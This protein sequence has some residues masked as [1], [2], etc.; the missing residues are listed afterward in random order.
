MQKYTQRKDGRYKT[1][2]WDGTYKD[3]EKHYIDV[4]STKSSRDLEMKVKEIEEKRQN[5]AIT[6]NTNVDVYDY[7]IAY[8]NRSKSVCEKSTKKNYMNAAYRLKSF[9]GLTF[10]NFTSQNIQEVFN[11][12]TPSTCVHVRLLIR[13]V[14]KAAEHDKLI[15]RGT[16]EE[17]FEHVYLPKYRAKEKKILDDTDKE[18]MLSADLPLQEKCFLYMLYYTGMRKSEALALT[19]DDIKDG[20]ISIT[21]AYGHG[22]DGYY[23]K[24]PKSERGTRRV[25]IPT[26][27]QEVLDQYLPVVDDPHGYLFAYDGNPWKNVK[28]DNI[29]KHIQKT[30]G[31]TITAHTLRHNYCTMLCYQS[32]MQRDITPK[33]I[34]ELL[35]DR[36]EMVMN[37][38][39]HI[40]EEK[41]N[42]VD[43]IEKALC[44]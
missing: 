1:R 17:I 3:G 21:K 40:V 26:R 24:P 43:A 33:K 41:E 27:L 7:I 37:V 2:V 11:S 39:S 20:Y 30:S 38:Y 5:G 42:T 14:G 12:I 16:T 29:W 4:Y 22:V 44:F 35:G 6:R 13:Q 28:F 31:V 8:I 15:P 36:E 18:K 25:P 32:V 9:K 34:A 10:D 19:V 23:I